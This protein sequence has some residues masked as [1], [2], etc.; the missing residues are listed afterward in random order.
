MKGLSVKCPM[1][2]GCFLLGNSKGF[3]AEVTFEAYKIVECGHKM[4]AKQAEEM[5][6]EDS[7]LRAVGI[8]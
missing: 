2:K 4:I 6:S 7:C 1:R 3:K 5:L 8:Y